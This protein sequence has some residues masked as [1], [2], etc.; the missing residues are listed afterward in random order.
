[1]QLKQFVERLGEKLDHELLE[2]GANVGV[3]ER[4]LICLARVLLQQNKIVI[5]DE[6]TALVDPDAER[7]IWNGVREKV[8]DSTVIPI[9]HRLNTIKDC[10][11]TVVLRNGQVKEFGRFD[12]LINREG[13]ALGKIARGANV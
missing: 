9:A 1:M 7:T 3:G 6:P 2:H 13:S 8:K 5:L 12:T 4:R 11:I 10:E